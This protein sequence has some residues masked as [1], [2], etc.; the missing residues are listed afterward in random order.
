MQVNGRSGSFETLLGVVLPRP[1]LSERS[2]PLRNPQQHRIRV[3]EW[4][5]TTSTSHIAGTTCCFGG[6]IACNLRETA[7]GVWWFTAC[8]TA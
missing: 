6:A 4:A 8:V 7:G 2:F 3:E 1:L 5:P